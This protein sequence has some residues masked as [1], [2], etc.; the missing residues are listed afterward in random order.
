MGVPYIVAPCEAEATCVAMLKQ[1]FVFAV[2]SEDGDCL[3]HGCSKLVR[4]LFNNR[5]DK[6]GKQISPTVFHLDVILQELEMTQDE[7][8]DLCIMCGCDYLD[9][10]KGMG[11]KTAY[12]MIKEY[13]SIEACISSGKIKE[14]ETEFIEN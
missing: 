7:F 4:Y 5:K 3:T 2:A 1:N 10:P 6:S 13:R 11:F 8:I 14:S 12:K 9:S